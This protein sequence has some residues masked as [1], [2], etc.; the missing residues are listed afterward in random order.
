MA[1]TTIQEVF[2]LMPSRFLPEQA[3]DMNAVIQ[4]NLSGEGG[5]QWLVTIANREAQAAQGTAANPTMTFSATA[6]DYLAIINGQL[7]A[8]NA[9]MQGKVKVKGDMALAMK[10]QKLFR[11]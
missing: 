3:G 7:N 8:M 4:F 10:M 1:V 6:A 2:D 5:G 9:F 11:A